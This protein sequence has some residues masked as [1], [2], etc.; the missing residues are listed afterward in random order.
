MWGQ[1][2]AVTDVA[3]LGCKWGRKQPGQFSILLP[4]WTGTAR[5]WIWLKV[6]GGHGDSVRFRWDLTGS[7]CL[8]AML[9]PQGKGS[10]YCYL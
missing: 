2:A 9:G 5:N 10:P 4:H 7:L 3:A 6:P 8:P 1:R